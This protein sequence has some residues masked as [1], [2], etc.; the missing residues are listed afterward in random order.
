MQPIY[1]LAYL[2]SEPLSPP[3]SIA[4]AARLGY[5]A[6]GLRAL[7][8]SPTGAYSRLIE[9]PALLRATAAMIRETGVPVF[10]MEIVRLAG[11]FSVDR[12]KPFLEASASLG[13]KAVLVAG[14]DPDEARLT[15]SYA[16]FCAAAYPFGLTA[17]LEFMPWTRVPDCKTALRIV[18]A[19]AQPNGGILVD[20]LHA[21]R[22]STTLA[23]LRALP[24]HLLHYA[25]LCDAPAGIP[26]TDAELI[27]TARAERLPPG[28]G[29]IDLKGI[30]DALPADLPLSLEI[31]NDRRKPVV[32]VEEWSRQALA[33]ARAVVATRAG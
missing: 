17:D 16:A 23:E 28:E 31:P 33:H 13:A 12:F 5:R 1:S 19:A 9:D 24:R 26:A 21:A 6:V 27:F 10:D 15:A 11:D 7:P 18:T 14:D 2:T 22:S 29:G 8:A 32:G 30:L 4:L 3:E 25:Q 20:A